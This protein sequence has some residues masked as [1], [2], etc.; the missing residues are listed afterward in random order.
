MMKNKDMNEWVLVS[1]W[2]PKIRYKALAAIL[3]E[4]TKEKGELTLFGLF[5]PAD[6]AN[7]W[8]LVVAAPEFEKGQ[9]ETISYFV[10]KMKTH[11]LYDEH[12]ALSRITVL[13][14]GDPVLEA[15]LD[16]IPSGQRQ[17]EFRDEEFNGYEI[18]RG[19]V[20]KAK[21]PSENGKLKVKKKQLKRTLL[22][23]R[24]VAA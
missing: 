12:L 18:K 9:M 19:Y 24:S 10:G 22:S 11:F 8:D 20:F 17:V 5:L 21:R 15:I 23:R 16:A 13:E 14:A 7:V 2:V 1:P 6:S 4:A 3:K